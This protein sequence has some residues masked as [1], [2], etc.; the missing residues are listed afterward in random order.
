MAK[1]V[2]SGSNHAHQPRNSDRIATITCGYWCQMPLDM[3]LHCLIHIVISLYDSCTLTT[4]IL[5]KRLR[6]RS[7]RLLRLVVPDSHENEIVLPDA[8]LPQDTFMLTTSV[9][10]VKVR[11]KNSWSIWL[12]VSYVLNMTL[13]YLMPTSNCFYDTS[14][15]HSMNS[16]CSLILFLSSSV[17][18]ICLFMPCS[19]LSSY[20]HKTV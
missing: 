8:Y 7:Y 17:P 20:P 13:Y 16:Y 2:I 10:S 14:S 3:K 15:V 19:H 18:R 12:V 6:Y 9:L 4:S 1:E 11:Y 5:F